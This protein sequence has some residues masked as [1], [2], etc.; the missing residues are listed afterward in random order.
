MARTSRT[1]FVILGIL[2]IAGQRKVSGYDLKQVIDRTIS[3]FW[4]E[5]YGQIYPVLKKMTSGG[6]IA[7]RDSSEGGRKK[8]VY[9]ITAKGRKS[10]AAWMERPPEEGPKRDE[11]LLKLIFGSQTHPSVLIRHLEAQRDRVKAASAPF[12]GWLKQ[13]ESQHEPNTVFQII[14]LRGGIA[15]CGAFVQWA[16]ES[17]AALN[18]MKG[19]K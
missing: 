11:L 14:T 9:T 7:A 17:L 16:D 8:T 3:Q 2:G 4:S 15:L 10:L 19:S 12:A 5:S 13:L 1:P 6:L 18:K